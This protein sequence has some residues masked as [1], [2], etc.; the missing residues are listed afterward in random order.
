[1]IIYI[2]QSY[3]CHTS[4]DGTMREFETDFFDNKC[5]EFIEG[6]RYVPANEVWTRE[7]GVSFSGEMICPWK[8]YTQLSAVQDAVDRTQSQ[9]D[10]EIMN[11]LDIIESIAMEG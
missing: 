8:D 5:P 9:A 11:L 3:H 2:D 10:A 4:N 1:M 6:Y 7:D